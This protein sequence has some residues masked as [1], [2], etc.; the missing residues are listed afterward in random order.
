MSSEGTLDPRSSLIGAALGLVVGGVAGFVGASR[1]V[2]PPRVA[3]PASASVAPTARAPA[4][5]V[6]PPE[7]K[8]PPLTA[9][10]SGKHLN[11]AKPSFAQQG[12]DLVMQQMLLLYGVTSPTY[13]DVGAH[14]PVRNSNTYVFYALGGHGVLVEP[15]PAYAELLRKERPRDTVLEVGVGVTKQAEADYYVLGGDGQ[16]NTFSKATADSR[17]RLH[18]GAIERVIKRKLV[19]LGQVLEEHFKDRAPDVLSIDVEGLD[20]DIIK[21]LDFNRW[22]PRIVCVETADAETGK[23]ERRILELL[24]KNGYTVRGGSFV[25]TIFLDERTP[26]PSVGPDAGAPAAVPS[27]TSAPSTP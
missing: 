6:A 21:T 11:Q 15:N 20:F 24:E 14:D 18:Q 19:P 22:R 5:S 9:T 1:D 16:L 12:E 13:L 26:R 10:L 17:V 3:P 2:E 7:G 8:G 25:N 23:V 27:G 4:A